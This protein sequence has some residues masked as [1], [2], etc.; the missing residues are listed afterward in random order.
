M[1][2]RFP[3]SDVVGID[4]V[5]VPVEPESIL[6]N[7]R[8]ELD[9]I[10]LGLNHFHSPDNQFDLIHARIMASGLQD[11]NK[12]M[13]DAQMC[14]KP[15]GILIWI[16]ADFEGFMSADGVPLP[17][18]SDEQP[19]GCWMARIGFGTLTTSLVHAIYD[20]CFCLWWFADYY[21]P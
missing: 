11:F 18:G 21:S 3:H 8:F 9:N 16:D 1:A 10:E 12:A 5:P 14:L 20:T 7:V 2:K 17:L 19:D 6:P 15:G 13:R 4:I